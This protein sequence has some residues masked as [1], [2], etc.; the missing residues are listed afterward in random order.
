MSQVN[1]SNFL[2]KDR[3]TG[4]FPDVPKIY[5]NG[6]VYDVYSMYNLAV[7]WETCIGLS[8]I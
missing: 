7:G 5:T 6:Y 3:S 4:M 1:R 2:V 8:K